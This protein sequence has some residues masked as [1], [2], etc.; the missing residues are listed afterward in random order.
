MG[1]G[2]AVAASGLVLTY[3]T[4]RVFNVAHGAIGMVMAF[5]YWELSAGGLVPG[6]LPAW[7]AVLLVV[8][9][10]APAFGLAVERIMMRRL[11]E[12]PAGVSLV[13]TVGL[14]V[15]L[16]GLAQ[17]LWPPT[18]RPVEPFFGAGGVRL[19]GVLVTYHDLLTIGVSLAVAAG[20]YLLL[21]RTRTGIAMR[22]VA[23][24]RDL[25]AL[26]GGR[27]RL[28]SS[29]SW[30]VG[31]ALAALAGILLTPIVQLDYYELTLLVVAAYAAA[32]LGRLRSLPLTFAGA[33]VL[34]LLQSY[35]AGL[36]AAIPTLFLF[37]VLV[38][39]PQV[40]LRSGGIRGIAAVP[41]PGPRRVAAAGLALVAAVGLASLLLPTVQVSRLALG[42]VYAT[43]MLSLVLLTGYG[44]HVSLAQFTF[45]GVGA[46]TVAKLGGSPGWPSPLA[47]LA[48]A[49]VAAAVGALVALP[50]LRLT[51]LYLALA[52]LAFGQLMDKV[53]F[54]TAFG[55][56][57]SLPVPRPREFA[58]EGAYAVFVAAV[59][60]VMAA[61]LL[62]LRRGRIG[63]MLVAMRDSPAACATLGL[64]QRG[65]RIGLFAASAGMAGLAGGLFGGLRGTIGAAD[66]QV[67]K[68][69]P[70]LLLAVVG[71]VTS[72]TGALLGGLVLMLLPILQSEVPALG[73]LVFLLVGIGAVSLGRD[74]GGAASHLFRA[75]RWAR[76]L[77]VRPPAG[78]VEDSTDAPDSRVETEGMSLRATP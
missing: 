52:T 6:G 33:V 70:L 45:V 64:N 67:F 16:I 14:L 78:P 71:G 59:F 40:R 63:R 19:G 61:G 31:A 49:A 25:L 26:H 9:V 44:G 73:G 2:Y 55:L 37:A 22:A 12:S 27:P 60:V 43:V 35:A 8:G 62:A 57:E 42:L 69:L 23:V 17:T 54:Q 7:A 72:V 50:V 51:G 77:V 34:G 68:S 20:L 28:L 58:G 4:S 38:F 30:A 5:C 56:G 76:S 48:G 18:A 41:V 74:P 29:L 32:V 13:V 53:V 3:T 1:A 75:G 39:L 66:F 46:V 47:L 21:G 65:L 36:R 24:D 10:I 11:T 15:A